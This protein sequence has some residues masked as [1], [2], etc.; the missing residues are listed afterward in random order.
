MW[1]EAKG[2][3]GDASPKGERKY[4][5]GLEKKN[6]NAVLELDWQVQV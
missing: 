3:L 4:S 1:L 5:L 2:F 6:P